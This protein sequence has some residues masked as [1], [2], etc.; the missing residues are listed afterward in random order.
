MENNGNLLLNDCQS[1]T[2]EPHSN[3]LGLMKLSWEKIIK[4]EKVSF[5]WILRRKSIFGFGVKDFGFRFLNILH[6][7][8][9]KMSTKVLNFR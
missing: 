3:V 2:R 7:I 5:V 8:E 6:E 9:R 4:M 1:N